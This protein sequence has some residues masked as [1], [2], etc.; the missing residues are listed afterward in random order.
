M[1]AK[2][3]KEGNRDYLVKTGNK[4]KD[5]TH[6]FQKFETIRSFGREVHNYELTPGDALEEQLNL[7]DKNDKSKGSTK[8]QNPD[9]K[10][11]KH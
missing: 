2:I 10:E 3:K 8:P 6:D 5:K 1:I 9:K 11:K 7:K 4:K